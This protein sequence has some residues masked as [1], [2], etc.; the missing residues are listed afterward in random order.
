[1]V[2]WKNYKNAVKNVQYALNIRTCC[3]WRLYSPNISLILNVTS[4]ADASN[5]QY[6]EMNASKLSASNFTVSDR[7]RYDVTCNFSIQSSGWNAWSNV[8]EVYKR[9][10]LAIGKYIL[11]SIQYYSVF[12]IGDTSLIAYTLN[13]ENV[14]YSHIFNVFKK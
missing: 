11:L 13:K 10:L 1:M 2:T 9:V 8:T 6:L 4:E 3:R 5:M 12:I 7:R 14:N